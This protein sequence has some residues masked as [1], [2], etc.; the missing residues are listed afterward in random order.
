[1]PKKVEQINDHFF[2]IKTLIT[3]AFIFS[4]QNVVD[5]PDY[6]YK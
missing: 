3:S 1:M 4:A 5:V 2:I 6:K